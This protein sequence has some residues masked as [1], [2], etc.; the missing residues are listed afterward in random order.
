MTSVEAFPPSMGLG[1][2]HANGSNKTAA[3]DGKLPSFDKIDSKI[4]GKM[5][6]KH[7][8]PNGKSNLSSSEPNGKSHLEPN[9]SSKT[10]TSK[11]SSGKTAPSSSLGARNPQDVIQRGIYKSN[12]LG[13]AA[14][15][16]LRALDP[17]LQYKFLAGDWGTRLLSKLNISSIPLYDYLVETTT[18]AGTK[19]AIIRYLPLPRLILLLMSAGS[20]LKQIYWLLG[21]SREELTPAA[22][23]EVSLFNTVINTLGSLLLLGTSTS[24]SLSTP[25]IT[26]PFSFNST[27]GTSMSL[28]LP[29]AIGSIMYIT[30]MAI[31][32]LTERT[33]K[34]FKDDDANEGKICREGLWNKARH[35]NYGGYTLWRAGYALAAGGWVPAL[36]VAAFHIWHFVSRSTVYM[37]EYMQ[38][39]YGDQWEKYKKDVPYLL[40]PGIY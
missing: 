8:E 30:G 2:E 22:A 36:G 15:I 24:A 20:S 4:D 9:G 5:N 3:A 33:R 10:G 1:S 35:I 19:S 11:S 14:F 34:K 12:P 21:L 23:V 37:S 7:A 27:T 16:G 25:R 31:E 17:I 6:G 13:T 28:P 38:S 40:I 39:R 29:I 26:L 18:A 32:T